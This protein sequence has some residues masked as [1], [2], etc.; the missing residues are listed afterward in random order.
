MKNVL[1]FGDSNTYGYD[2][3][4][5]RDG[6]AVRYAQDVRWC[7]VAQRD[8]GE[9]WHVIEEGLNGRT[10]V[11]DDMCHLDTNLNGIRALPMLLEAH[12]PLDAIERLPAIQTAILEN[13]CRYVRPGGTL[14]YSTCTVRKEENEDVARTFLLAHPEFSPEP[15]AVPAGLDLKNEGYATLLPQKHAADGFFICKLRRHA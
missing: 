8:L 12:K 13:V 4:G 3:A 15:F 9:G 7:G 11:R 1:C 5:M 10:T 14:L 6:T 2:P